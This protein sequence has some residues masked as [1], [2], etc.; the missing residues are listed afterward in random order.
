MEKV[1]KIISYICVLFTSCLSINKQPISFKYYINDSLVKTESGFYTKKNELFTYFIGNS[2]D[3]FC[4]LRY[5]NKALYY[6][7]LKCSLIDSIIINEEKRQ[8]FIQKYKYD[9]PNVN[10]EELIVF[11]SVDYGIVVTYSYIWDTM[12]IFDKNK[13]F[14]ISQLLNKVNL[15]EIPPPP[16][17]GIQE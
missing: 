17:R 15:H 11:F 6:N 8:I 1:I 10:D 7:E 4:E 3:T 16:E 14:P 12:Y 2:C 9:K 5:K 13:N